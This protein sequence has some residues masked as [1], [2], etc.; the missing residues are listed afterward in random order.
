MVKQEG[1]EMILNRAGFAVVWTVL[2]IVLLTV[3]PNRFAH[4][5]CALQPTAVQHFA[6]VAN[7]LRAQPDRN[8]VRDGYISD[9]N[10]L[11]A[12]SNMILESRIALAFNISPR[13]AWWESHLSYG[14]YVVIYENQIASQKGGKNKCNR[15]N[16]DRGCMDQSLDDILPVIESWA[17]NDPPKLIVKSLHNNGQV[18]SKEVISYEFMGQNLLDPQMSLE[19][20]LD[21]F[22]EVTHE[23]QC[24]NGGIGV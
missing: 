14:K 22:V 11:A 2:T 1:L 20:V 16:L 9:I 15:R 3:L 23:Y 6:V 13:Q 5:Q 10:A 17:N 18:V 8:Q 7:S 12:Y 21:D 4:A 19:E 24:E